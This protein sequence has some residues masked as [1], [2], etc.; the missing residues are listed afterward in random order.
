[1]LILYILVIYLLIIYTL[2]IHMLILYIVII[3]ISG[4][5]QSY[6]RYLFFT[7]D[8]LLFILWNIY[9]PSYLHAVLFT[10]LITYINLILNTILLTPQLIIPTYIFLY[11]FHKLI[12]NKYTIILS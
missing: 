10:H 9:T 7:H 5:I 11:T 8:Y 3:Y 1:M 12:Y 6:L 2:V 4:Y